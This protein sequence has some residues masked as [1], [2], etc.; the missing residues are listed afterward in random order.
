[1]RFL[2][3]L[4]FALPCLAQPTLPALPT[5]LLNPTVPTITGTNRTVC[6][7]G[8]TTTT[9]QAAWDLSTCGDG[10]TIT[11]GQTFSSAA[12]IL[13]MT[14]KACAGSILV[15]S[16][17]TCKAIGNRAGSADAANMPKL[18]VT[19]NN[20]FVIQ[21]DYTNGTPSLRAAHDV[22]LLCLEL[23]IGPGVTQ[24]FGVF[25]L[26]DGASVAGMPNN[27]TLDRCWLHP[28][29]IATAGQDF[30]RGVFNEGNRTAIINNTIHKWA[31]TNGLDSQAVEIS[32]GAV[33][34]VRNNYLDSATEPLM[35][36]GT[37]D[38]LPDNMPTDW[39]ISFNYFKKDS[40]FAVSGFNAKNCL[41][42][43]DGLRM[44]AHDNLLEF[45]YSTSGQVGSGVLITSRP[46]DSGL[47]NYDKDTTV[48]GN[49]FR[50]IGQAYTINHND[51]LCHS[52]PPDCPLGSLALVQ[53]NLFDDISNNYNGNIG[54]ADSILGTVITTTVDHNTLRIGSNPPSAMTVMYMG[55]LTAG[56]PNNFNNTAITFNIG[57]EPTPMSADGQVTAGAILIA[58]YATGYTLLNNNIM[59]GAI[60]GRDDWNTVGSSNIFPASLAA[61]MLLPSGKGLD[62]ASP[63]F[64]TGAGAN[65]VTCFDET[66]ITNGTP[67]STS[68]VT[69]NPPP[70]VGVHVTGN[71]RI[72]GNTSIH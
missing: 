63:Y 56:P 26:I 18:I 41:E 7:S 66:A 46:N 45:C 52:P 23:T 61:I 60:P 58:P 57:A 47:R 11:A 59:G 43:K 72:T 21:N 13:N 44:W 16:S 32:A 39:E 10:I 48:V 17:A 9:V 8:C 33:G 14:F 35:S 29:H 49:I 70:T 50:H 54:I 36:G 55:A 12:T 64:S 4:L 2:A 34:L 37:S 6:S 40:A 15:Q 20:Q 31:S 65:L 51:S 1:M 5:T 53:N 30:V 24:N 62:P 38:G 67:A 27:I 19:G 42:F 22:Y 69:N 3:A 25:A 28:D 68:C 71:V